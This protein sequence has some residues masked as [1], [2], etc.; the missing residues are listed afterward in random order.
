[1][2]GAEKTLLVI[3]ILVSWAFGLLLYYLFGGRF[4]IQMILIAA[5]VGVVL[6]LAF[7]SLLALLSEDMMPAVVAFALGSLG[8]FLV[9]QDITIYLGLALLILILGFIYWAMRVKY[10]R[11][12]Y[13]GFSVST[14]FSGMTMFL[15]ILAA[16]GGLLYY[17]S[18]LVTREL[19]S[20]RVPEK[21]FDV[22]Y[23]PASTILNSFSEG[24]AQ[25]QR[26]SAQQLKPQIYQVV[27]AS[28]AQLARQYQQYIPFVFAGG[29][30][31]FLRALFLP[32]SYLIFFAAFLLIKLFLAAGW[33]HKET[34]QVPREIVKF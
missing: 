15:T 2:S 3:S 4:S 32:L 8:F 24:L 16:F 10:A 6:W 7:F 17:Y 12:S 28:L 18:P 11:E 23:E 19:N 13:Q 33:L 20:P 26:I 14:M 30:F 22:I 5:S 25:G 9:T 21:F 1:M 29:V 34:I 31:L 27:N